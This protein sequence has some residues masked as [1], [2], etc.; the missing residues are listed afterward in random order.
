[1]LELKEDFVKDEY[2][3]LKREIVRSKEEIKRIQSVPL[4][5]GQFLEM[6]DEN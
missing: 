2:K 5:I 3:Q 1:M 4:C 6:I